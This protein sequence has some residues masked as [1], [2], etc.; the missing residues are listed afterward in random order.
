MLTS[1]ISIGG[2]RMYFE[3]KIDVKIE[4]T[5]EKYLKKINYIEIYLPTYIAETVSNSLKNKLEVENNIFS[6]NVFKKFLLH[7]F[8][9]VSFNFLYEF[10]LL[11]INF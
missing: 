5:L 7:A 3:M 8:L 6:E 4:W 2:T 10:V 1:A 9:D 11:K